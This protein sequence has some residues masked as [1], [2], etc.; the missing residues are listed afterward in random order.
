MALELK[1]L[2]S[3]FASTREALHHVAAELV[4]PARK[5]HNEIAL[6]PAP[7]GFGTPEFEFEGQTLEVRVEGVDLVLVRDAAEERVELRS[8]A[9]GRALLGPALLP[10]GV[11]AAEAALDLDAEAAERLAEVFAFG[12]RVLGCVKSALPPDADSSPTVL[13]PEHFD[14]AF[15]AGAEATGQRATYGVSPGDAEHAE[16]YAYVAPWAA[17]VSGKLWDASGFRG[18]ELDYSELLRAG[19]PGAVAMEFMRARYD[20]LAG[21]S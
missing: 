9:A 13:W 1:P 15:E 2:P 6:R 19:D 10:G 4:A 5:P 3:S 20:A 11:P 7:G 17:E 21:P 12:E 16:P 18:A 14:V 8:L